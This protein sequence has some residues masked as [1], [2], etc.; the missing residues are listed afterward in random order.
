MQ[1]WSFC[2]MLF[3]YF[4]FNIVRW[5][6]VLQNPSKLILDVLVSWL[7][8]FFVLGSIVYGM[9]YLETEGL[10]FVLIGIQS[11]ILVGFDLYYYENQLKSS[12][13]LIAIQ[14]VKV[15]FFILLGF[16]SLLSFF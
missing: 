12:D 8:V 5:Q 14:L 4:L 15:A 3:A 6:Y 11:L 1:L 13:Y 9:I 2:F 16:W 7:I 10:Y